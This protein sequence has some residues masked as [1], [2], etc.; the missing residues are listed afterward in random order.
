MIFKTAFLAVHKNPLGT[1]KRTAPHPQKQL[2]YKYP[3]KTMLKFLSRGFSEVLLTWTS[4][5]RT[6][7]Q[8]T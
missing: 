8:F 4:Q 5:E 2:S 7:G 3:H 6:P 1:I